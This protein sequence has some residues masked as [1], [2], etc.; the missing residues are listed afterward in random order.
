MGGAFI[1]VHRKLIIELTG[2]HKISTFS[3]SRKMPM[4]GGLISYGVG[5]PD[6]FARAAQY[7]DRIGDD[8]VAWGWQTDR[9]P[10]RARSNC[11]ES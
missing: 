4:E 6:L 2:R 1:V 8:P 7:V 3:F 10:L 5:G 9:T 11:L